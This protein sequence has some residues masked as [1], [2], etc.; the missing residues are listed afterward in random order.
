VTNHWLRQ[1][2]KK[3]NHFWTAEFSKNGIF[4]LKPRRVGVVQPR[5]SLG[6]MGA[7][8]GRV[9]IEFKNG[10]TNASDKEL[11]DFMIESRKSMTG[12]LA[13]LHH[14]ANLSNELEYFELTDLSFKYVGS[15]AS[16]EDV[17][18]QFDYK[19]IKHVHCT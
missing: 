3:K 8:S 18:M 2:E 4:C 1:R 6:Y 7:T 15:G 19:A 10:M 5:L 14:Y 12:W 9:E 17:A 13:R 16:I 11:V